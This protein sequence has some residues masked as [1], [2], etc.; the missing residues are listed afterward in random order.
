MNIEKLKQAIEVTR[1]LEGGEESGCVCPNGEVCIV[2]LQRGWVY[3]GK[4]YQ[5]GAN[6]RLEEAKNVRNWGTTKGLGEIAL[7]GPT[8]KTVLDDSPTVKFHELTVV[9]S[10]VCEAKKWQKQFK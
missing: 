10:L 2:I 6:C 7:N 8:D 3:V 5:D 9:A 4:F 1:L